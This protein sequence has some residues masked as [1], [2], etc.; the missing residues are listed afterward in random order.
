MI[1]SAKT[2]AEKVCYCDHVPMAAEFKLKTKKSRN[3]SKN[4]ELGSIEI[5]PDPSRKIPC[6]YSK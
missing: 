4:I 6:G 3:K 1:L 5:H 2:F